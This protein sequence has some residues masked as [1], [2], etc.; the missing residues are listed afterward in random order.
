[1][2]EF[3]A[4]NPPG[5]QT[6]SSCDGVSTGDPYREVNNTDMYCSHNQVNAVFRNNHML[7]RFG[8]AQQAI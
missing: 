7:R 2:Q 4:L 3:W 5:A 6:N 8:P 1:M